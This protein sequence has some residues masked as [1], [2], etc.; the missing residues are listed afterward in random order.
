L[1]G[2]DDVEGKEVQ[3]KCIQMNGFSDLGSFWGLDWLDVW[4]FKSIG[5]GYK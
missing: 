3:F 2:Y 4:L 1:V 5:F